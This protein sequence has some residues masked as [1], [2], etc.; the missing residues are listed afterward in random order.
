MV[1]RSSS[2]AIVGRPP[3]RSSTTLA[4]AA[5]SR[6]GGGAS[7][8]PGNARTIWR[9]VP[10]TVRSCIQVRTMPASDQAI[11]KAPNLVV[12]IENVVG[13][14]R[15]SNTATRETVA[16]RAARDDRLGAALYSA[17]T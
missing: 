8:A 15:L 10:S 14:I 6:G 1:A 5:A 4:I 7:A 9:L 12:A 3:A 2:T 17:G 13:F 16:R 11:P